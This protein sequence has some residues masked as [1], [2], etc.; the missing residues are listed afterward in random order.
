MM[1]SLFSIRLL[2]P[3]GELKAGHPMERFHQDY[4]LETSILGVGAFAMV[5]L[6]TRKLDKNQVA[7]KIIDKSKL[8]KHVLKDLHK[9]VSILANLQHQN[10]V[11][12]H[13]VFEDE[14]K[15]S[16]VMQRALGGD[17]FGEIIAKG[18]SEFGLTENDIRLVCFKVI[19]A[20][21]HLR[22]VGVVHRDLKPDNILIG[23]RGD[24]RT[25]LIA[26][27][28]FAYQYE[29]ATSPEVS[30]LSTQCGSPAYAAPEVMNPRIR[31]YNYKVDVWS[32]G[33]IIYVLCCGY[34]PFGVTLAQLNPEAAKDAAPGALKKKNLVTTNVQLTQAL[35]EFRKGKFSFL[36]EN[37]WKNISPAAKEV[38]TAMLE[39]NP[40]ARSSYREVLGSDWLRDFGELESELETARL[41]ELET[42]G[43]E[44]VKNFMGRIDVT[45]LRKLKLQMK[46]LKAAQI[47]LAAA[48]FEELM[49]TEEEKE[50]LNAENQEYRRQHKAI[51]VSKEQQERLNVAALSDSID[52]FEDLLQDDSTEEPQNSNG[53][54][55]SRQAT[56]MEQ[57]IHN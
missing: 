18:E 47:K 10:I 43:F 39:A 16:I 41:R 13:D 20:L 29:E 35:A 26:D 40:K 25:V 28:G 49:L 17:L 48:R 23:K 54:N 57:N 52:M 31:N 32:M 7:V 24:L 34:T 51:S 1:G 53:A 2:G 5:K 3:K 6:A 11:V 8:Q 36:P 14:R 56:M 22:D 44:V 45:P 42:S 4:E 38:I 37:E 9:E 12:L 50:K 46:L 55:F 15:M 30:L 21:E 33:T 27:F 19:S